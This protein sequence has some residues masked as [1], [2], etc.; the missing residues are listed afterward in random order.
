MV[1]FSSRSLKTREKYTSF[2]QLVWL[3]CIF[4]EGSVFTFQFLNDK[5]QN[6]VKNKHNCEFYHSKIYKLSKTN[7]FFPRF[8]GTRGERNQIF[9]T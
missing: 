6:Y 5:I 2:A 8:E 3:S 7:T 1:S 9:R 4:F